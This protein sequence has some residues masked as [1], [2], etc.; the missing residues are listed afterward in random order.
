MSYKFVIHLNFFGPL[1]LRGP[2]CKVN[3]ENL[4]FLIISITQV[5]GPQALL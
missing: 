3:M 1:G 4:W 5:K 2:K